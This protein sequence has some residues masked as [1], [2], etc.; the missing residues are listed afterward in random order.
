MQLTVQAGNIAAFQADAIVVNLFEGVTS[1][2]GGT[3]AVDAA[4]GGAISDLIRAGDVR[5]KLGEFTLV[6]TLGRLPSP[7][8]IIAGLGKQSEFDLDKVRN[9]SGDLARYH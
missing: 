3:G 6:H 2:G 4:M 1:L 8:V 9:L 7:R 5:G